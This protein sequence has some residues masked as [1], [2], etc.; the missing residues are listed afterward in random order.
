[1]GARLSSL[2]LGETAAAQAHGGAVT[3]RV[4]GGS[5][6]SPYYDYRPSLPPA[7]EAG[8]TYV[9][10]ADGIRSAH[11]FRVGTARG[12][13]PPWVTGS[14]TGIVGS[15][16]AI[17]MA[18]P[19]DYT[20]D[21]VLYCEAHASMTLAKAVATKRTARPTTTK[22]ARA[23]DDEG[24]Y[25]DYGGGGYDGFDYNDGGYGRGGGGYDDFEYGDG[26]YG[27]GGGGFG[28]FGNRC[29]AVGAVSAV[30]AVFDRAVLAR[31]GA[32]EA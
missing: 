3:I 12:K 25:D 23:Y 9:F 2:H 29:G 27:R 13:T 7:F 30:G 19:A 4:S 21:V 18:V 6:A 8:T 14:T 17:T 31:R 11:P 22:V 5:F 26:G 24:Y 10:A 20:G 28:D 1:M 32:N 15:E 16:G